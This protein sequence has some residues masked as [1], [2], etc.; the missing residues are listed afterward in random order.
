MILL[1]LN[2]IST[3]CFILRAMMTLL[4]VAGVPKV[5][6][7]LMKNSLSAR[8]ALGSTGVCEADAD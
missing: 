1:R 2:S 6:S 3:T 7:V 5:R 8:Y 4:R